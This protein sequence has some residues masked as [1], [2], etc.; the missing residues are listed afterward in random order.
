MND[1]LSPILKLPTDGWDWEVSQPEWMLERLIPAKSIGMLF[2]PSNAGKSHLVCDLILDC[3]AG[4]PTWQG[5]PLTG[6]D[7]VMFSESH[8]HIKARLKAYRN[9]KNA[10]IKHRMHTIPTMGIE[11]KDMSDLAIW[12][13]QL[14]RPP[15]LMVFDTLATAF[16]IEENDNKEASKL[17]NALE[18][19]ILPAMDERGTIMLVHHTS[20]ISEGKTARGA[21]AL[22]GNIDY[23]IN[24]QWDEVSER[25]MA[26]WDKDRW[27][28]VSEPPQWSGAAKRVPVAFTNGDTEMMVLDWSLYTEKD[29]EAA[30]ELQ[31]D[32]QM[33][34]AQDAA[35][36][37]I[38]RVIT[39]FG[40]AYLRLARKSDI[41]AAH[42]NHKV[43]LRGLFDNK[44]TEPVK[45]WLLQ[46]L[47]APEYVFNRKNERIGV[48]IKEGDFEKPDK[49]KPL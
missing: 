13:Y 3:L 28:L 29:A 41:P 27:R 19:W 9:H 7:V 14:P 10:A 30:R 24:C 32:L 11:T 4:Q 35:K 21:S 38:N 43:S 46:Q 16:A 39:R 2:G 26:K 22:I 12:V 36:Q 17:I 48:V 31:K 20:N 44:L 25:T 18:D 34:V 40:K 15:V 5:I 1:E 37:E 42:E 23:S 47:D 45:D 33:Q 49:P 6:G 8:G